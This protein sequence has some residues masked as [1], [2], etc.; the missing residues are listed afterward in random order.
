MRLAIQEQP[1]LDCPPVNAV[2]LK[3]MSLINSARRVAVTTI[4]VS[5]PL[6]A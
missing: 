5:A 3:G 6:V 2:T 4:S 1:R